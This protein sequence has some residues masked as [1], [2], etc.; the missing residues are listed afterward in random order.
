[1]FVPTCDKYATIMTG[2]NEGKAVNEGEAV[3]GGEAD[4][5]TVGP[6]TAASTSA[7]IGTVVGSTSP[8]ASGATSV[9]VSRIEE[10]SFD[11]ASKVVEIAETLGAVN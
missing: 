8:S 6:K 7:V 1:M 11:C 2:L 5:L 9:I 4:G 10:E 3:D